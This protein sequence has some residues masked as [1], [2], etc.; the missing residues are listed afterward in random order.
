[1]NC[2]RCVHRLQQVIGQCPLDRKGQCF[3]DIINYP[4]VAKEIPKEILRQGK[5]YKN[6]PPSRGDWFIDY[7]VEFLFLYKGSGR[8][9]RKA[10]VDIGY[11]SKTGSWKIVK[12]KEIS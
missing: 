8:W 6:N 4:K 2:K 12:K 1:M 7:D 10:L 5:F 9:I 3:L 11:N